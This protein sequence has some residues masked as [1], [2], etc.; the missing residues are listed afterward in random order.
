[1]KKAKSLELRNKPRKKNPI[2]RRY[3]NERIS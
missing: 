1:M 3:K 2:S